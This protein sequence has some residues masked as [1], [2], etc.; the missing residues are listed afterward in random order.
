MRKIPNELRSQKRNASRSL[1]V[2]DRHGLFI[3]NHM[4]AFG[5]LKFRN[6][7]PRI[8]CFSREDK[9]ISLRAVKSVVLISAKLRIV[10]CEFKTLQNELH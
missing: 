1:P 6:G 3:S 9:V 10:P 5:L 8:E 7:L 4:S 2:T